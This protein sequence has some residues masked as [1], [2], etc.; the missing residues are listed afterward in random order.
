MYVLKKNKTRKN[1]YT[2]KFPFHLCNMQ[3][4]KNELPRFSCEIWKPN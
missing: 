4:K 1:S 2:E 3:T